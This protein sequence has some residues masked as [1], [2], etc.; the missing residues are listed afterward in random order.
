MAVAAERG[1]APPYDEGLF[2]EIQD[3]AWKP[4][5]R[6][7]ERDECATRLRSLGILQ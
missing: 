3:E 2:L 4:L 6:S 5:K 7:R 1:A